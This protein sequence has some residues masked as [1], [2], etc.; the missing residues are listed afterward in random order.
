[1]RLR[2]KYPAHNIQVPLDHFDPTT[3]VTFP[4]RYWVDTTYYEPGGP[5]FCL[6][7]GET[8]GEDRLPFL[9][10]GILKLLSQ[11]TKGL[12]IVLEHRYYGE[13]FGVPDLST[14]NMRFLTTLQALADNAYFTKHAEVKGLTEE[15]EKAFKNAKWI[16][17]GGRCVSLGDCMPRGLIELRK[18]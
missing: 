3:N 7:G 5:V 16:H 8:S 10:H 4:L 15:Q 17:Y 1:M 6:D 12:A 14:D 18:H 2:E 13:S 9:D 11:A